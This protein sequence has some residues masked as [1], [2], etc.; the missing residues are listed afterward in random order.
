M[1]LHLSWALCGLLPAL[2]LAG[3]AGADAIVL[4]EASEVTA[5]R[6]TAPEEGATGIRRGSNHF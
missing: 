3:C 1:K 6:V 2:A 5:V 4:P